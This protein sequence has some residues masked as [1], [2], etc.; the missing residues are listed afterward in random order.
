MISVDETDFVKKGACSLGVSRQ[1]CGRLGKRENCQAGVFL[2]YAN[3]NGH[4]LYDCQLYIPK[5]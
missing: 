1:Y 4:A 2:A 5:K 3:K